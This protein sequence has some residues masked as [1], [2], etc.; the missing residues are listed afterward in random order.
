MQTFSLRQ[1][2]NGPNGNN[3][4][5][6]QVDEDCRLVSQNYIFIKLFPE[7]EQI[8]NLTILTHLR[9]GM[10]IHALSVCACAAHH[11][12]DWTLWEK[13]SRARRQNST[14]RCINLHIQQQMATEDWIVKM[15]CVCRQNVP[16]KKLKQQQIRACVCGLQRNMATND[17]TPSWWY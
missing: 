6:A 11:L 14:F 13:T 17:P 3:I 4:S 7:K 10:N 9:N 16:N 1:L 5:G 8:N 2:V 12:S 15:N